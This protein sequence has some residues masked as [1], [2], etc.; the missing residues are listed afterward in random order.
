MREYHKIQTVFFRDMENNSKRLLEGQWSKP[1]FNLLRNIEWVCTE[2]IDG[3][4]IRIL[5]DGFQ[6]EFK[7]K[8][9]RAD[10]PKHLLNYLKE[11]FTIE[12]M[13]KEFGKNYNEED[14][15]IKVCLYG[16]GFGYKIQKGSNY[17]GNNVSFILFDIKVGHWW[18]KREDIEKIANNLQIEIVTII[19]IMTLREAIEY[20]RKGFKSTIAQN[21][22]YEAEGLICKPKEELFARNGERIIT[23]IKTCDF[24]IN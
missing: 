1:E 7:G 11:T 9:D 5:W 3:T 13:E 15:K 22:D 24:K 6:V 19:G 4:N 14:E 18:L 8:T 20:V 23:K 10:I 21:K 16:E 2:K 12:K 17:L